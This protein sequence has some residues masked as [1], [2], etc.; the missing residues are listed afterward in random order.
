MTSRHRDRF[1]ALDE[2]RNRARRRLAVCFESNVPIV[3]FDGAV[4]AR[5]ATLGE[6][7]KVA[8][9]ETRITLRWPE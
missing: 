1:P 7:E 5:C 8:R 3:T 2:L 6:A 9:G 4:V